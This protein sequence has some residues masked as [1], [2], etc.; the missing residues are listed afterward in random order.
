MRKSLLTVAVSMLTIGSLSAQS[1]DVVVAK[2]GS[3][4]FD[5]IQDAVLSIRDYKPEGRQRI[6]VRKGVYEEKL[7]I[8][9]YKTNITLVGEDSDS[10]ILIWHDH[11]NIRTLS[12]RPG[13]GTSITDGRS[14]RPIG[15]FQSYTLLVAGPGF[16]CE[17][18]TIS[19]DAML[20]WNPGWQQHKKNEAGVGQAVAVHVEADRCVFR[21]CR[22]L[23]F[24]DTVFNGNADSRQLFWHCYIEGT[25]DFLF[26]PATCWFEQ[27][28]IHA[29]GN[30]YITAAST[31]AHHPYGYVFNQ[32]IVTADPTV[33]RQYLGRPWRNDAA[34]IFKEC[35]LSE[36]IDPQGWNNWKDPAREKTSRYYEV[37]CSG[38]GA[39]TASRVGWVRTMHAAEANTLSYEKVFSRV[40]EPW[41]QHVAGA[42]FKVLSR[43]FYTPVSAQGTPYVASTLE[44]KTLPTDL[45]NAVE[46]LVCNLDEVDCTTFVE[47]LSAAVISRCSQI[48]SSDSIQ[49]R[50]L[51][52][53]RYRGG[54]RGNYATRKHYFSEWIS[55]GESQLMMDEITSSLPGSQP[56]RKTINFMSSH[57]QSYPQLAASKDL[58]KSIREVEQ[59][60]SSQTVSYIPLD[61]LSSIMPQLRMGD[62]V[63][64][65]TDIGGL[66]IQHVGFVWIEDER[67]VPQLLHA[68]SA[69]HQVVVSDKSLADYARSLKHCIGVRIVRL[70]H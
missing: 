69:A 1:F 55:D 43:R 47:Y 2:D 6:L 46:P 59:R 39:V 65:V 31:P 48:S 35:F 51:Q 44:P 50:F 32:C 63:A 34:V 12:G 15:T 56:L 26:G 37:N 64:F 49:L 36:S 4:D 3:G 45:V 42:S 66:D 24:Q 5:N 14:G 70:R 54:R 30:G 29:I 57:P 67:S 53:L 9:T 16:E 22:L 21:N 7:I 28:T 27:C 10:T 17:N 58:V 60:L 11:A 40:N 33:T 19:N 25:V 52:A 61:H 41:P 68:S 13:D 62:I 8:P 23:G 18:M 38:P 20:H